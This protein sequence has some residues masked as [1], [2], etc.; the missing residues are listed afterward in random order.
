MSLQISSM[1]LLSRFEYSD[2]SWLYYYYHYYYHWY[3]SEYWVVRVFPSF[4][5]G[6]TGL[7]RWSP[8]LR[9]PGDGDDNQD[10]ECPARVSLTSFVSFITSTRDPCY[11]FSP[12][13]TSQAQPPPTT[14]PDLLINLEREWV[15]PGRGLAAR[16]HEMT[17]LTRTWLFIGAHLSNSSKLKF[18]PGSKAVASI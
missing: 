4:H 7:V 1:S 8:I 12:P 10:L 6:W 3:A 16:W 11:V 2:C 13:H 17:Q 18:S 5:S 15:T 9:I 14:S